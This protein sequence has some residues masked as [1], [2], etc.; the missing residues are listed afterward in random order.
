MSFAVSSLLIPIQLCGGKKTKYSKYINVFRVFLSFSLTFDAI[1]C[2]CDYKIRNIL[3]YHFLYILFKSFIKKM[4]KSVA[5]LSLKR[6]VQGARKC[7]P[8]GFSRLFGD[9]KWAVTEKIFLIFSRKIY[10]TLPNLCKWPEMVLLNIPLKTASFQRLYFIFNFK[11]W[12]VTYM[13]HFYFLHLQQKNRSLIR[14]T[15]CALFDCVL[16]LMVNNGC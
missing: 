12:N 8:A 11:T 6:T 3:R 9:L 7:I 15:V 5:P 2:Y 14:A 10:C 16:T 4:K 1:P 13:L